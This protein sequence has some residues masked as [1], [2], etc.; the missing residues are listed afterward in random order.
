MPTNIRATL[1][2]YFHK[3]R[4]KYFPRGTFP[5]KREDGRIERKRDFYGSGS[6]TRTACQADC[7]RLNRELE[8]AALADDVPTFEQAAETYLEGGGDGRFLD[9][10]LLDFVGSWRCDAIDDA[11][12][13]RA[14]KAL[15]PTATAATVNR[16]LY[17]PVISVLRLASKGK[18]WKPSLSRPKG[19]SKLKPAKAPADD[20]FDRLKAEA[21]PQL[22]A[23]LLF[24]TLHGRRPSDGLRRVPSDYDPVA[25]TVMI[26]KDKNGNPI[27]VRLSEPVVEAIQAYNWQA[28]PGL[29]GTLTWKARR[30]AYRML[31]SACKRAGVEY[32][33]LHKAGRHKFAKRLLEAG[34]SLAHVKSAGRWAS[35][36]VVAE[37][38]GHLE[39]SE[40]DE[41]TREVGVAWARERG[42]L[43]NN[44]V[45]MPKR[46]DKT[47]AN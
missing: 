23:L 14:V 5:I 32:F 39:H 45:Q 10:R 13:V 40:V 24:G 28:G 25:Q 18:Q 6:D 27:L 26:D 43:K 16:Q 17:T 19:Y 29:F 1:K 41:V 2:P 21:P 42:K 9:D 36:R 22:W 8:L 35:I 31:R 7:D 33:T 47:V 37:L 4:R 30:N 38:Y 12:M 3:Q 44:V 15:Y 20:W 46:G 11:M 34:Y